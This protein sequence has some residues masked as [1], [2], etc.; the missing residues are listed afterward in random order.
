VKIFSLS[1]NERIKEK[2]IFDKL[3]KSGK[4]IL[5]KNNSLKI[6]YLTEKSEEHFVK[7]AIGISK[8]SGKSYW[9]NRLKR[10]IRNAYRLNKLQLFDLILQKKISIYILF[11]SVSINQLNS[12]KLSYKEIEE[13][14]VSLL[15]LLYSKLESTYN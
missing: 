6:V 1:K 9:R 14:V 12:Q 7:I 5:S 4:T 13:Q 2:K 8:K 11:S 10:L 15:E 3:F